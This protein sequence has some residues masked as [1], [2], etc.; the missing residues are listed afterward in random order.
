[1][2]V[3]AV[4]YITAYIS[5]QGYIDDERGGDTE[6]NNGSFARCTACGFHGTVKNF[7]KESE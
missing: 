5:S 1:M 3:E 2:A 6:W 7:W 4:R